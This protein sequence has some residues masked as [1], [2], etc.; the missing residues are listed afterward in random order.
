MTK[1]YRI[2]CSTCGKV[3]ERKVFCSGACRTKAYRDKT[4]VEITDLGDNGTEMAPPVRK[5]KPNLGTPPSIVEKVQEI[6][7]H[8]MEVPEFT[9]TPVS[10]TNFKVAVAEESG[11]CPHGAMV[12]ANHG[13]CK[14]GCTLKGFSAKGKKGKKD[15]ETEEWKKEFLKFGWE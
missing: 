10:P 13:L 8:K 7:N 2:P 5:Q 12:W 11:V 3:L 9:S 4:K 14:Y 6:Q 15:K 1:I